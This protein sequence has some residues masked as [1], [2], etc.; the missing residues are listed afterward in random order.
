[1]AEC[2][3][4]CNEEGGL[5]IQL[6]T[7]EPNAFADGVEAKSRL[8]MFSTYAKIELGIVR[9]HFEI[10]TGT[11]NS[12]WQIDTA[13][14]SISLTTQRNKSRHTNRSDSFFIVL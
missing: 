6:V 7:D 13:L 1:M 10:G 2:I 11:A 3:S 8:S 9:C 12:R 14:S 5:H 4:Q